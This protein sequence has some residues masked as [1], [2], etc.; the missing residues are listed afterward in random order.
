MVKQ[1]YDMYGEK[2]LEILFLAVIDENFLK[3][4]LMLKG[5]TILHFHAKLHNREI[6]VDILYLIWN[7]AH[8]EG[9]Q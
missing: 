6:C 9:L 2:K 5:F 3:L 1:Q 7:V 8:M 4:K